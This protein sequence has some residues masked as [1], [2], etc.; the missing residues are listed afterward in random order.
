MI[1]LAQV[2]HTTSLAAVNAAVADGGTRNVN[3]RVYG[4]A[5]ESAHAN[6]QSGDGYIVVQVGK[7]RFIPLSGNGDGTWTEK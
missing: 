6:E 7:D 4:H 5:L 1:I 2:T 3:V